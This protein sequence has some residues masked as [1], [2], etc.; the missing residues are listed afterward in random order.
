MLD[1]RRRRLIGMST[2]P[3]AWRRPLI[4]DTVAALC[5]AA[6]SVTAV[7]NRPGQ[8]PRAVDWVVTA[9]VPFVLLGQRRAPV[10]VVWAIIAAAWLAAAVSLQTPAIALVAVV[11]L[12]PLARQRPLRFVWPPALVIAA[13]IA[14]TWIR[15]GH[16]WTQLWAFGAALAAL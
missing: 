2:V 4:T 16:P 11:A 6:V 13:S 12:Y 7:F 10:G 1:G 8:S 14:V 9:V 5:V 3:P 15:D